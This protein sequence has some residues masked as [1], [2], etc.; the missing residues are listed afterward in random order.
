[1]LIDSR[2]SISSDQSPQSLYPS[3]TFEG[4]GGIGGRPG[5][6]GIGGGFFKHL[7]FEHENPSHAGKFDFLISKGPSL[8]SSRSKGGLSRN[9]RN[10][11][12]FSTILG[13]YF[14]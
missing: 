5:I 9:K 13:I 12:N 11:Q 1:M 14:V 8:K 2:Q 6:G 4:G 7:P 10:S 3:Q